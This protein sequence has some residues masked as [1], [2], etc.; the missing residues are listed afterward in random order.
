MPGFLLSVT[1]V[2]HHRE[3]GRGPE[4]RISQRAPSFE[5][6]R[7]EH[8]WLHR[9]NATAGQ[10]AGPCGSLVDAKDSARWVFGC[11]LQQIHAYAL[12]W[13]HQPL[14][15]YYRAQGA[16]SGPRGRNPVSIL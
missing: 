12:R 11:L 8:C 9:P 5:D 15:G 16:R 1:T 10:F 7:V 14:G 4:R 2:T 6:A 13:G 3:Y